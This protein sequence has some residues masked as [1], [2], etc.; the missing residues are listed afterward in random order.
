MSGVKAPKSLRSTVSVKR[1]VEK[2][3]TN[4]GKATIACL[5]AVG[6]ISGAEAQQSTLPPVTVDAPVARPKPPAAKPSREQI[7]VRNA[8]RRQAARQ[9]QP[10]P[11]SVAPANSNENRADRNPYADPNAPYKVDRLA[12]PKFTEPVLNTPRTITVLTKELLEDKNATTLKEIGRSTAGVTLG[13]GEGGNAFGDRFFIRGFDA[14]N[15]VFIDGVRDSSVSIRENFFTEQVEILRGPASSFAG[16]GTAGGAI[17]IVTKQ[18]GD[19]NFYN[20]DV[21]YGTPFNKRVVVDTNQV[22]NPTLSFRFS[23]LYQEGAVPGRDFADDDRWGTLAAVKWTP[24]NWFTVTANYIHTDLHARPDFGVPWDRRANTPSTET[25]VPANRWYGFINRDY[26]DTR[27]DLGTINVEA[28]LNDIFTVNNRVRYAK[29]FLGYIGTL[30]EAPRPAQLNNQ[31]VQLNPQSR[32]QFQYTLANQTDFTAKYVLGP[33]KHT[34]VFG[35]EASREQLSFDSFRGLQSEALPGGTNGPAPQVSIFSPPNFQPFP[36]FN[37]QLIGNATIRPINT[38]SG[39]VIDTANYQDF[40]ILNGGLRYD[41]Y[42]IASRNATGSRSV[43]SGIP[44]YNVGLTVKPLPNASVYAAYATSSNPVG[45]EV[46]GTTAQ[47]GGLPATV[48]T[49]TNQVFT[50]ERNKAGEV[51]TKWEL[52]DRRLLATAAL[53]ETK[54]DNARELGTINGIANTVVAGASYRIRGIDL[55]VSGK[56][57]DRWS[58]FGGLV[59]MESEV[60]S[61]NVPPASIA[62]NRALFASNVGLPLSNIAHKSFSLLS[63]YQVTDKFEL[64]GQAVWRS[65]I[66]GGTFLAANQGTEIPGYWR[67]DAFAEYKIDK[68]LTAK[69][70]AN[71]LTDKRYYDALYQSAAPF[72]IVAPGRSITAML[73]AKY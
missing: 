17:N 56:I 41:D 14:R 10:A 4:S 59:L 46:D 66:Y 52:F 7:R 69:L 32:S 58:V 42:D 61:S 8:I 55:G 70:F 45:S 30:A 65:Q 2:L 47:Y 39:Y 60:L 28:K 38:I 57:T 24:S 9:A 51:G 43:H 25:L 35:V 21:S 31:L 62:N 53:F 50:P 63:K 71:N 13:T 40:V 48:A 68:H 36:N 5:V 72:V 6:S 67:Y 18:A 49:N 34:T 1:V 23:G 29:S 73:S 20:T 15:D 44:A 3:D 54:K 16:R 22:I 11:P 37:P 27:Q 12:S 64:G 33:F 19:R 26:Q